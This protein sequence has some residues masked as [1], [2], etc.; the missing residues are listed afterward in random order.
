[1]AGVVIGCVAGG[2]AGGIAWGCRG[3][4]AVL[5][6]VLHGVLQ[7]GFPWG[8]GGRGLGDVAMS[9]QGVLYGEVAGG[10]G[11]C[12]VCAWGVRGI[13][14]GLMHG[15]ALLGVAEGF[16]WGCPIRCCRGS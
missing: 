5:P 10:E 6:G 13:L 16:A 7:W 14:Q 15:G 8:E 9:V 4:A 1:M 11:G 2:L 3:G 12:M